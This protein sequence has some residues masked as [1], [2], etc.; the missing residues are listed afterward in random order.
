MV[1]VF[2]MTYDIRSWV[3]KIKIGRVE[4]LKITGKNRTF[5]SEN[6]NMNRETFRIVRL[7]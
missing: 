3:E 6:M 2:T 4:E 7:D 1:P 5:T